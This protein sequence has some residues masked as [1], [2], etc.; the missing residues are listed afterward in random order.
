M[1]L[2]ART[3][4]WA[5]SGGG[6]PTARDYVQDGLIAMWDGIE[7]A[8]WGVHDA[9][10][11]VWKDLV[12]SVEASNGQYGIYEWKLNALVLPGIKM[13]KLSFTLQ[14]L[15]DAVNQ[16]NVS[17]ECVFKPEHGTAVGNNAIFGFGISQRILWIW[18]VG[19]TT[20]RGS[21]KDQLQA[22][23]TDGVVNG[24]TYSGGNIYKNG[25]L[26]GVAS[27]GTQTATENK[28]QIGQIG[29]FY[30]IVGNYTSLCGDVHSI[31]V[32]NRNITPAEIVANY[33]IDKARFNLT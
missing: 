31:R 23:I 13:H 32:Y 26:H 29:G 22:F 19:R 17:V 10:A 18:N 4:A 8:G 5:K 27:V 33:A 14:S 24:I 25:F 7:N 21:Q 12:G 20:I 9:S 11:T 28:G 1:M 3:G 16:N 6:V 2:G 30:S 15:T